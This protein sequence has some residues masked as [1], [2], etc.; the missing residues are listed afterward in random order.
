MPLLIRIASQQDGAVSQEL[1]G[2]S[3]VV[4]QMITEKQTFY[5]SFS[6]PKVRYEIGVLGYRWV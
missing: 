5:V 3:G 2:P 4:E 1:S 6:H